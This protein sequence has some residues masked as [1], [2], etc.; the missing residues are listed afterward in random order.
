MREYWA[1]KKEAERV[2]ASGTDMSAVVG[3]VA[4]TRK[5]GID[6]VVSLSGGDVESGEC[7]SS[8]DGCYSAADGESSDASRSTDRG[9]GTRRRNSAESAGH[10]KRKGERQHARKRSRD[11]KEHRKSKS[12]RSDD[13][14]HKRKRSRDHHT[15][16]KKKQRDH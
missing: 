14:K 10:I 6:R 16:S 11:R 13:D 9:H 5:G 8:D 1:K 15:H 3:M 12:R 2:G 7:T 4:E